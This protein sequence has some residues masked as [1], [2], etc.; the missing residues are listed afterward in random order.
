VIVGAV[1]TAVLFTIGKSLI[2]WYIGSSAV[3][4]LRRKTSELHQPIALPSHTRGGSRM[5]ESRPYRALPSRRVYIPK[6]DGR[7]RPL[8]FAAVYKVLP[9]RTGGMKSR[10]SRH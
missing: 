7:Q 1:V 4:S 10:L 5:R 9:D 2:S 3:A 8:L 6:P